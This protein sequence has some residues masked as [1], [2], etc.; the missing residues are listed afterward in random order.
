MPEILFAHHAHAG[1][2]FHKELR[3]RYTSVDYIFSPA[4]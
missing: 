4:L 2:Q 3:I 1:K